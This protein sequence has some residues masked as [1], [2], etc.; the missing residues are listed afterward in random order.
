MELLG[1][2]KGSENTFEDEDRWVLAVEI[3]KSLDLNFIAVPRMG[4]QYGEKGWTS[5]YLR[6]GLKTRPSLNTRKS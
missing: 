4:T 3:K 1:F 2:I 6:G 5:Q